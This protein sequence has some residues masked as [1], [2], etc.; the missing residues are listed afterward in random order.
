MAEQGVVGGD[1]QVGVGRLVEV[2]AVAVA[3]GLEDRDLLE[4][5]QGAVARLRVGVPR[6]D[7]CAPL[8]NVPLG[9]YF[10]SPGAIRNSESRGP[11]SSA[12]CSPP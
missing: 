11:S 12:F 8:R 6:A 2:P 10:T 7:R 4:V 9:G 3:L 5:L 1:H